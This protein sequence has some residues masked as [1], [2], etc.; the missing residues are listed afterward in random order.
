M[1]KGGWNVLR[2]VKQLFSQ[3]DI[4]V[5]LTAITAYDLSAQ[6]LGGNAH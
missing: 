3:D 1:F 2:D 5:S 6:C 4:G